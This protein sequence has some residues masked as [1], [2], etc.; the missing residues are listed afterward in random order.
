MNSSHPTVTLESQLV[1]RSRALTIVTVV[2]VITALIPI[3]AVAGL[4]LWILFAVSHFE[5]PGEVSETSL[6]FYGVL[7]FLLCPLLGVF[8]LKWWPVAASLLL[9]LTAGVLLISV[10]FYAGYTYLPIPVL[11][12]ISAA[13]TFRRAQLLRAAPSA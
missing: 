1:Q 3:F 13:A 11:F 8:I 10:L 2:A 12:A 6:L 5:K 4:S 9:F 7:T